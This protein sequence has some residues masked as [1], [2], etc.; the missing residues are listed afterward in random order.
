MKT[1]WNSRKEREKGTGEKERK[2]RSRFPDC[3]TREYLEQ[4]ERRRVQ[5][6]RRRC[7]GVRPVPRR[8]K[9]RL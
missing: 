9:V 4:E 6:K 3:E 5:G 7:G 8:T 1:S 2:T